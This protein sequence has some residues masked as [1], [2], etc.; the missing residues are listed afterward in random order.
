[1]SEETGHKVGEGVH[2]TRSTK[3]WYLE[4]IKK[5]DKTVFFKKKVKNVIENG[6]KALNSHFT[7]EETQRVNS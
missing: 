3:D 1:M 7:I 4:Y 5:S 6:L 2:N